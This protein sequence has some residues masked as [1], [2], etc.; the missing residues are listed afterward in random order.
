MIDLMQKIRQVLQRNTSTIH[1]AVNTRRE[2]VVNSTD[3]NIVVPQ[4]NNL[5]KEELKKLSENFSIKTLESNLIKQKEELI[6]Q[7]TAEITFGDDFFIRGRIHEI[8]SMLK[9]LKPV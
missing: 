9:I 6:K 5:F 1:N 7:Q 8:D 3:F 4:L 2:S